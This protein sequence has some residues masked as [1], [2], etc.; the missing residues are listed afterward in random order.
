MINGSLGS[1]SC[2]KFDNSY[3]LF[4]ESFLSIVFVHVFI[5]LFEYLLQK[6]LAYILCVLYETFRSY[7]E[8]KL[9]MYISQKLQNILCKHVFSKN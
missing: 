8:N 1:C 3:Q 5:K 7:V 9:K 6:T 4:A 2:F